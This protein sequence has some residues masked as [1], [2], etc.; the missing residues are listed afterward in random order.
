MNIKY[1]NFFDSKSKSKIK[2]I[3][4]ESF[5]ESEKFP[6]WILKKCSKSRNVFFNEILDDDKTIGIEYVITDND[7]AYLMYFAIEEN[8][9]NKGYGSAIL[10]DLMKKYSVVIL[11][12]EST[13]PNDK[14]AKRRKEFYLRNRFYGSGKF[15]EQNDIEYELL[16]SNNN[17]N[18]IK[19]KL[20]NI[21]KKMTNSKLLEYLINKRFNLYDIKFVEN[22]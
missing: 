18:I 21:Y 5:P 2:G 20:I 15:T 12:I 1:I 6:F 14:I 4:N 10:N 22:E 9:R 17:Y 13:N 16:C 8:K 7:T 11:S 3:Y 19:N